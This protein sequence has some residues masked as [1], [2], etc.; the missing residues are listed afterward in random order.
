VGQLPLK[1]LSV[2]TDES[3]LEAYKVMTREKIDL[4]PAVDRGAS[5][6]IVGVLTSEAVARAYEKAKN[7]R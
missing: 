7:L 3:I 6:K 2:F 4:L 1:H 5:D